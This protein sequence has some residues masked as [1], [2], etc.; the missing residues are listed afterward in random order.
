M[1]LSAAI[2]LLVL[3][4]HNANAFVVTPPTTTTRTT[5][6]LLFAATDKAGDDVKTEV[7]S[8]E[9]ATQEEEEESRNVECF[10]VGQGD[11]VGPDGE[12][13][14]VVCTSHPEEY[15]WLNGI[16]PQA[17]TPTDGME[18]GSLECVEGHPTRGGVDEYECKK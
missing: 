16:D 8:A 4:A 5:Q 13:P 6:S 2:L 12:K 18:E 7:A 17:M 3:V 14:E 9:T 15:A 10:V 1:R 11:L